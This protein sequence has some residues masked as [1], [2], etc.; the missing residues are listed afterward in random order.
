MQF[1]V[2]L[3]FKKIALAKQATLTDAGKN[4]IAYA[5]QKIFKLKEEIEVFKDLSLIHIS[6]PTRPY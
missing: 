2:K 4:P 5:R 1:P 6:E 3:D